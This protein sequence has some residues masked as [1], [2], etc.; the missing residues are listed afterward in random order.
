MRMHE[1]GVPNNLSS[2]IY[3][4]Y[5][6]YYTY[7]FFADLQPAFLAGA[8]LKGS[9]ELASSFLLYE[10]LNASMPRLPQPHYLD[11][12]AVPFVLAQLITEPISR[13]SC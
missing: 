9:I 1:L 10:S 4:Y 5:T 2:I 12:E 3:L 8:L 11:Y 13:I 7:D 6:I